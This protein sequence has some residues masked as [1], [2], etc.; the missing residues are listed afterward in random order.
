MTS[1]EVTVVSVPSLDINQQAMS[2]LSKLT[3]NSDI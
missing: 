2:A 1:S 3:I